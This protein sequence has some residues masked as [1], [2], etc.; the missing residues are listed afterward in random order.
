MFYCL[1]LSGEG[2]QKAFTNLRTKLTKIL[3]AEGASG[4]AASGSGKGKGKTGWLDNWTKVVL[5]WLRPHL[6][7]TPQRGST[8]H[9]RLE[10]ETG[11]TVGTDSDLDSDASSVQ[12]L[13]SLQSH[14]GLQS[15]ASSH[16]SVPSA[17][18][19]GGPPRN[20]TVAATVHPPP[21]QAAPQ[22]LQQVDEVI[23]NLFM[24]EHAS[25]MSHIDL[26]KYRLEYLIFDM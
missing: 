15:H 9:L 7:R 5:S 6:K 11:H 23:N 12:S 25:H 1:L 16:H 2:L 4:S 14:T 24:T 3:K 19:R 26:M 8:S 20:R 21:P 10:Q 18:G 13:A 22:Q 17:A